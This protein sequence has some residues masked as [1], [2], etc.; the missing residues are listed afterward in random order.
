MDSLV[1][2]VNGHHYGS[3][4]RFLQPNTSLS[5]LSACRIVLARPTELAARSAAA[6]RFAP[7][8]LDVAFT[9]L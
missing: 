2:L 3:E 8:I 7:I 1:L 9:P 4:P 6:H 5:C